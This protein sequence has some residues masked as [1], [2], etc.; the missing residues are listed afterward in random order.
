MCVGDKI[1]SPNVTPVSTHNEGL[2][3]NYETIKR[4]KNSCSCPANFKQGFSSN[5]SSNRD[6][7]SYG[8]SMSLKSPPPVVCSCC[9]KRP[10]SSTVSGQS[11]VFVANNANR[12]NDFSNMYKRGSNNNNA[13]TYGRACQCKVDKSQ[14][15]LKKSGGY[16]GYKEC[17]YMWI[18]DVR[19]YN[20]VPRIRDASCSCYVAEYF[21]NTSGCYRPNKMIFNGICSCVECTKKLK[22]APLQL[23][24]DQ[25]DG[26]VS[27]RSVVDS[28]ISLIQNHPNI[29]H[30]ARDV[31]AKELRYTEPKYENVLKIA[32][33]DPKYANVAETNHKYGDRVGPEGENSQDEVQYENVPSAKKQRAIASRIFSASANNLYLVSSVD[34]KCCNTDYAPS[35]STYSANRSDTFPQ[36][37]QKEVRGGELNSLNYAKNVFDVKNSARSTTTV[38]ELRVIY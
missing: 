25:C 36:Y 27:V 22:S 6:V 7:K 16:C 20:G 3:P 2:Y 10:R 8:P 15:Q 28:G 35:I 13:K 26:K 14:Q 1:P 21:H 32:D 31:Y 4:Y 17:S 12:V 19:K 29:S 9:E 30:Y 5:T 18:E 34:V 11:F 24:V 23:G 33:P 38:V 37:L